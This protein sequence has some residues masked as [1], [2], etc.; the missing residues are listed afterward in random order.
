[1]MQAWDLGQTGDDLH[2]ASGHKATHLIK[3]LDTQEHLVQKMIH[4]KV[5][6]E[7][8]C[9]QVIRIN[10]NSTSIKSQP[11]LESSIWG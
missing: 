8:S 9:F 11:K 7:L 3:E 1:M 6:Q 4:V 10:V 5:H 2:S